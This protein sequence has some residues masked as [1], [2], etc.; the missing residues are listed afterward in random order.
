VSEQPVDYSLV[1]TLQARVG[2]ALADE[3]QQRANRHQP[4]LSGS[5]VRQ[6]SLAL[7]RAAVSRH[8]QEQLRQG[9]SVPEGDFDSRLV[10]A[11]DAAIWGAGELQEYLNDP[12][13]ENLDA[14]GCDQVF[15]TY[16]D[17]RGRVA[18][19][20][21]AATD[22]DLIDTVR[23]LGAYGMNARPFTPSSPELDLRLPDGS[24]LSAIMSAAERP[25]VSIRRNRFP[26]IF[27]GSIPA[28]AYAHSEPGQAPASLL[29][30][31][32]IDD[33]LAAFL[34]A[35]VL[36]RANIIVAGA[37][38]AGK[39]T[40]LRA[41]I[42]CTPNEERLITVE[43]AL[44]LGIDRHR[45]L[46]PNVAAMEEVLPGAD[47]SGGLSIG[48][49]VRRTRRQ[50]PDRVIVGEVLG[51]EVVEMLSAMSQGNDGSLSTIHARSAVDVFARLAV[52]AAQHEGLD[53][54]VT[55]ALVGGAIDFV[56]FVAKN[57]LLGGKRTVT[58]VVEV[59]GSSGGNVTRSR[60]FA[61]SVMD[62]HAER[63]SPVSIM[64]ADVLARFGY[65]DR[66]WSPSW[67]QFDQSGY[68]QNGYGR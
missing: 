31:G 25:L 8:V 4:E 30:L 54:E 20:P 13:V 51:P 37:T 36:A 55:H 66:S 44:E 33:R 60:I 29:E 15:V 3:R 49:L 1:R 10:A 47:G 16:A 42:N 68:G 61:P 24:R 35:A 11:I 18:V 34:E 48:Q 21:V 40:L 46:H 45:H 67:H 26:Q 22:E 12:L 14:N 39:T 9:L 28:I 2:N 59:T 52:Y 53:V 32:T 64:R 63:D 27:L 58:E 57:P 6:L 5:D 23:T 41:L 17:A 38:D 65:D 62:G 19:P 50:N 43:R 56:V 7:T